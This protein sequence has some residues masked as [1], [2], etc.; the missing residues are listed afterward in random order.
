MSTRA[1]AGS[2]RE[3]EGVTQHRQ[4]GTTRAPCAAFALSSSAPPP[5]QF[6]PEKSG[7]TGLSIL[8]SFLETSSVA[9]PAQAAAP[10]AAAHAHA[11]S[12]G[13][14]LNGA[15]GLAKR[16]IACLDVRSNDQG[17]LVVTKV[18]ASRHEM[19]LSVCSAP[20]GFRAA[21]A[22]CDWRPRP[23][24]HVWHGPEARAERRAQ[25]SPASAR[26]GELTRAPCGVW[27][28]ARRVRM[29]AQ[30]DQYDVREKEG[31]RD[32]RNLGKPVELAARYFDEGADEVT[33][34]NITGFRDAPLQ[35]L[36]MLEV[37]KQ[38]RGVWAGLGGCGVD[39]GGRVRWWVLQVLVQVRCLGAAGMGVVANA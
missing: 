37:L 31:S 6:H 1:G 30:G 34:L 9:Q 33:F 29:R 12:S 24:R 5:L 21:R 39:V 32:V 4:A 23:V 17:D 7:T 20:C 8:R 25:P 19:H 15:G 18:R 35:D 22:A 26:A 16:V 28:V 13:G 11:G 27:R 36:P 14:G 38:V 2:T 3:G 10:A